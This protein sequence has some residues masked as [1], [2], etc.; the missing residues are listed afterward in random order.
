MPLMIHHSLFLRIL[1]AISVGGFLTTIHNI[2]DVAAA[3]AYLDGALG[4][5]GRGKHSRHTM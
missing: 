1:W 2:T 4:L 5:S 3:R